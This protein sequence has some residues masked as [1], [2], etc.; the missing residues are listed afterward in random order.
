MHNFIVYKIYENSTSIN[1]E[2]SNYNGMIAI[3][4]NGWKLYEDSGRE[5]PTYDIGYWS[6]HI[7]SNIIL[8]KGDIIKVT[9]YCHGET[10]NIITLR[11][12]G[13]K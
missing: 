2:R 7:P 8:K 3:L 12:R 13:K 9:Q 4:P 10:T 5:S 6:I 1:G 11:V